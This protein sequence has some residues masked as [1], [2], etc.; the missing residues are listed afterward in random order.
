MSNASVICL[1]VFFLSN[2]ILVG[3]ALDEGFPRNTGNRPAWKAW[4][5]VAALALGGGFIIAI[6]AAWEGGLKR[7]VW[8]R[9]LRK[10]VTK[11][12]LDFWWLWLTSNELQD[13]DYDTFVKNKMG[14]DKMAARRKEKGIKTPWLH[15]K[16]LDTYLKHHQNQ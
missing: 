5:V 13:H 14:S 2:G 7:V 6:L 4:V 15:R 1:C 16:A 3:L 10:I 9:L 12:A 8:D 11:Y